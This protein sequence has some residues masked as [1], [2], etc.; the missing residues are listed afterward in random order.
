MIS[1]FLQL[2]QQLE[3]IFDTHSQAQLPLIQQSLNARQ[4]VFV[5][6]L[7][8]KILLA[9]EQLDR[10]QNINLLNQAFAKVINKIH[11]KYRTIQREAIFAYPTL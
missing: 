9:I 2:L 6:Y 4:V 7:H 8:L 5:I 3:T 1:H 11:F 10:A